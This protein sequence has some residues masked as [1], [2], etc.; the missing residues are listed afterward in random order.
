MYF[1]LYTDCIIVKGAIHDAIYDLHSGHFLRIKKRI[2]KLLIEDFKKHTLQEVRDKYPDWNEGIDA[3]IKKLTNENLAFL[4]R[5][6]Q[7]FPPLNLEYHSPFFLDNAIVHLNKDFDFTQAILELME[8]DTRAFQLVFDNPS[9]SELQKYINLF[10]GSIVR[11]V[12]VLIRHSSLSY[13]D[14]KSIDDDLRF[15][16]RN[17]NI[18]ELLKGDL[19]ALPEEHLDRLQYLFNSDGLDLAKKEVYGVDIFTMDLKLFIEA[20]TRNIGLNKKVCIDKVFKK[21]DCHYDPVADHWTE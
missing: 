14:L 18:N 2:S 13:A 1:Q 16:Y 21:D 8:L 10:K 5:E 9:I 6:P 15:V 12:D 3:Y 11:R 20:K 17:F 19:E 7:K 4:T